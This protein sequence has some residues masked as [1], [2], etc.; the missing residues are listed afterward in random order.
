MDTY[1]TPETNPKFWA[2]IS[3]NSYVSDLSGPLQLHHDVGDSEVPLRF[4]QELYDEVKAAGKTAE[5]YTY[6][7]DDHNIANSF[8]LAMQRTIQFFDRYVKQAGQ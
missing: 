5:M 4:S 1:G 8:N 7:G 2:S 6:P 3:P